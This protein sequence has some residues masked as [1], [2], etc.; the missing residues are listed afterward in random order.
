MGNRAVVIVTDRDGD[1]ICLYAHWGG[2]VLIDQVQTALRKYPGRW[3]DFAYIN[4]IIFSEMIKNDID[5]ELGFG[6][7]CNDID[8]DANQ[9]I[10]IDLHQQTV[11]INHK[12]MSIKEF[13]DNPHSW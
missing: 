10:Q 2:T 6:I 8:F 13:C 9:I 7:S 4:R 1:K 11:T 12:N 3:N 5:S